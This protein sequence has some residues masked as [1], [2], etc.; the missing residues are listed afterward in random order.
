MSKDYPGQDSELRDSR[1]QGKIQRP[2][3]SRERTGA[4]PPAMDL[5]RCTTDPVG[6]GNQVDGKPL[7]DFNFGGST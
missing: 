3:R 4:L 1:I 7:L 5:L 6:L 2:V